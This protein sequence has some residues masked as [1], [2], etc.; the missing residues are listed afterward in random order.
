MP[1]A[2]V[3]QSAGLGQVRPIPAKNVH[4]RPDN[5]GIGV[6]RQVRITRRFLELPLIQLR[7]QLRKLFVVRGLR[8]RLAD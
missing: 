6:H 8:A 7:E 1:A 5:L 3:K 4:L 2:P